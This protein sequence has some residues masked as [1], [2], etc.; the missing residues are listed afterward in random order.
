MGLSAQQMAA[1]QMGGQQPSPEETQAPQQAQEEAQRQEMLRRFNILQK[2]IYG[3]IFL[4]VMMMLIGAI[5]RLTDSGLSIVD[6]H[7]IAD[8]LPPFTQAD[9]Q[10]LFE[11]YKQLPEYK[12]DNND[13]GLA[14]FKTIYWWEYIHRLWGR[15]IGFCY[16]IPLIFFIKFA[17]IPAGHRGAFI[18]IL[19][20]GGC[21]ALAG[22]WMVSSG[23][24]ENRIDVAAN[25]LAVHLTLAMMI[26]YY[27]IGKLIDI[28]RHV[29][30]KAEPS[31]IPSS[32]MSFLRFNYVF[33]II[34]IISG[35]FVA[36]LRAGWIYNEYPLM[37]GQIIPDD[38]YSGAFFLSNM[39]ENPT[40]AQFHHRILT[41]L[42]TLSTFIMAG[43][44]IFVT[45]TQSRVSKIAY[46]M[47]GI[48]TVQFL[49]GIITLLLAV[50][51][52]LGTLHQL[53]A[54]ALFAIYTIMIKEVTKWEPPKTPPPPRRGENQQY[55]E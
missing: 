35:A 9:W 31:W 20:L 6:W 11:K 19:V 27:L 8:I 24:Q 23:Q 32:L 34:V 44:M 14:E 43:L 17:Y 26:L 18:G 30:T 51:I 28:R 22:M 13:F 7:V 36:G 39:S 12:I 55:Q 38:Y 5:T 15:I 4:V 37:G 21:Q 47:V 54:I 40:A 49:L 48:V 45:G 41:I 46:I 42:L 1:M 3:I 2:W 52:V 50:P 25:R 29:V 33:I 16:I 53:G 10:I